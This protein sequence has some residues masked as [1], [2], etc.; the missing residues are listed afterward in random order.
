MT[1]KLSFNIKY[2]IISILLIHALGIT[3]FS[4]SK[5]S[6]IIIH[7]G[8]VN[9]IGKDYVIINDEDQFD[10]FSPGDTFFDSDERAKI[11][12]SELTSYGT[13]FT[14]YGRP[15]RH[16]FLTI[17]LW[18]M[19]PTRLFSGTISGQ[20]FD[21]GSGLQLIKVPSYNAAVVEAVLTCQ[22]WDSV[23]NTGGVLALI[24]GR[25]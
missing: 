11:Y 21:P 15:G 14:S 5:I 6:G 23:T 12:T 18:K 2:L 16:E 4:Q 25:T 22:P 19:P 13:A 9:D 1:G 17:L 24:V 20:T 7:Y 10:Q 3:L 8:R